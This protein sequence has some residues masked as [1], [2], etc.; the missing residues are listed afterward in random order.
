VLVRIAYSA[1]LPTPDEVIRSLGSDNG[2]GASVRPQGNGAGASAGPSASQSFAP[3]F[4]APRG[5]PRS[6]AATSPRPADDPVAML[7]D[8]QP[9]AA[10]TLTLGTFDEIIALVAE[11]RDISMRLSLERDVRLVRCEDGQLEITLEPSA[12]RTLVHDL[13]RKLTGWTGKRWIVVISKEQGAAT[14]RERI[15]EQRA[16]VERGVQSDPLVQAVLSRFP[17]AKIVGVTQNTPEA[18]E[19]LAEPEIDEDN[20]D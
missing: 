17:G 20:E 16:E 6:S 1:D 13:Q 12:P 3:R 14:V 15:E 2:G 4:E 9:Q 7:G 18:S 5:A 11:K 8:G 19:T 10:P